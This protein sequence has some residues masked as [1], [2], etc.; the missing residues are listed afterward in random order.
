MIKKIVITGAPST[1]K[2][3]IINALKKEGY[4]CAEEISRE[5][6]AEQIDIGGNILPWKDQIAFENQIANRRYKQY[7]DSP[8]N[9]ICFFDRSSI[10]CI[11]YLNSNKLEA[12][13]R[14]IEIIKNC[15]FNKTVFITPIWEEIFENDLERKE[16]I[17]QSKK[18]EKQLI[19]CYQSFGYNIVEIP[20]LSI[21]ERVNFI[22]SNIK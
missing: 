18:I 7:L 3:T 9:C 13:S 22:I 2:T 15:T 16:N 8:E 5:L 19:K 4:S 11:A 14:I 20:K 10:D 1:G 21:E 17:E 12:T 6:I